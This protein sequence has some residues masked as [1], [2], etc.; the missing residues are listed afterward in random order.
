M[1][2]YKFFC[3]SLFI[4]FTLLINHVNAKNN[5]YPLLGKVIYLDPGH[6]GVDPGA[7]Y[8]DIKESDINLQISEVLSETLGNMGAIVYMTRYGDYDLGVINAVNRKRSDLS[9]RGNIINRSGCDAYISI[10]LNADESP[11]WY[12]AQV[13]YDDV[14]DNNLEFAKIMQEELSR[15]L[16]TKRKYKKISDM[17]LHR[18]IKQPGIL[19]EVGFLSNPNERYLLRQKYYQQKLSRIIA[20]G[21]VKFLNR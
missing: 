1:A 2:K 15:N 21:V 13:F 18:R 20:G 7:Y 3:I 9:R 5:E 8:K 12:G 17:Y 11:V 10:H 14:I 16:R 19:I 6:G 4:I